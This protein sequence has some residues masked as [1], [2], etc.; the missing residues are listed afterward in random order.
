MNSFGEFVFDDAVAV[1]DLK[2]LQDYVVAI[3]SKGIVPILSS[4]HLSHLTRVKEDILFAMSNDPNSFYREFRLRKKSGGYREIKAPLPSLA[5]VQRWLLRNV[6]EPM[7]P[8]STCKS[9]RTGYS[10]LDNARYHR[11][12]NKVLKLD[13]LNF[14]GSLRAR[15]V[16]NLFQGVGYTKSVSTLLTNLCCLEG[17]LPQG[18]PTSGAISNLLLREFDEE[19]L[20]FSQSNGI[21][22]TRYADDMT[23]SGKDFDLKSVK[24]KVSSELNILRLKLNPSKIRCFSRAQRQEVTGVVVNDKLSVPLEYRKKLRQELYYINKFGISAHARFLRYASVRS[25]LESLIGKVAYVKSVHKKEKFWRDSHSS[26]L[27]MR[28]EL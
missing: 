2:L 3:S 18:A 27:L 24:Q 4:A 16:Y 5:Y 14:F 9:Y 1:D 26:L 10:T 12:Q 13:V 25:C 11:G 22:Y 20:N 19:I 28:A 8:H 15:W 6:L 7:E 17:V 23:F 21:R